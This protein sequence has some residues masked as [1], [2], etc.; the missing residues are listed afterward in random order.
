MSLLNI[1]SLSLF[2]IF[3]ISYLLKL[4]ILYKRNG[5]KANVLA[6]KGKSVEI[7]SAE[8]LVKASTFIWGGLWFLFSI[9][10]SGAGQ[11]ISSGAKFSSVRYVGLIVT[12]VGVS[13]FITAMLSMRTSWRV[14]IDKT[15]KAKLVSSGIYRYSRNPAFVGFDTMFIG[16]VLMYPNL[17][18][19]AVAIL[20][21]AAI[22]KLILQEEKHL[23]AVFGYEYFEYKEKTARYILIK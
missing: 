22:H 23:G 10:D 20:N 16:F 12:A 9:L 6:K 3:F 14:G 19:L 13:I 1:I 7:S 11:L 5:I 21:I 8:R 4:V 18:T 15:T 17:L 2:F